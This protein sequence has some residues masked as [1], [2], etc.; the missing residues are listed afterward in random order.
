MG[1]VVKPGRKSAPESLEACPECRYTLSRRSTWCPYCGVQLTHP[2]WK[3]VGAWILL[4]LIVYGLVQCHL[5]LLDG[6][7][8]LNSLP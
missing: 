7:E 5:R 4:V 3:K 8:G 1:F 6:P 2:P